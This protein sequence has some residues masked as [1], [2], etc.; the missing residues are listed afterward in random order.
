MTMDRGGTIVWLIRVV[1]LPLLI[2]ILWR[3]AP[4]IAAAYRYRLP[5]LSLVYVLLAAGLM[6]SSLFAEATLRRNG[7]TFFRGGVFVLLGACACSLAIG[8]SPGLFLPSVLLSALVVVVLALVGAAV[9]GP[10]ATYGSRAA[11]VLFCFAAGAAWQAG[12]L[13]AIATVVVRH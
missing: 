2:S 11:L 3:S 5:A 10:S 4:D 1:T 7:I 12:A 8:N 9:S 13:P 6:V